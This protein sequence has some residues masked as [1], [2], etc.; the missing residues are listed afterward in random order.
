MRLFMANIARGNYLRVFIE[1]TLMLCL[2][3]SV[4]GE[5]VNDVQVT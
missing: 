4:W 2:S 1:V 3:V 5:A